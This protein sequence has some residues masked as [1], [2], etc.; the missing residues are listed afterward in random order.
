MKKNS[1]LILFL[2]AITIALP[3]CVKK[4]KIS[5]N[6]SS[7]D[8]KLLPYEKRLLLE[9]EKTENYYTEKKESTNNKYELDFK[10]KN[11]TG[12]TI[13]VVCFSYINKRSFNRWRWDKSPIYKIENN[14]EIIIDIDTINDDEYRKNTYGTL[15]IFNNL[16]K[17]KRSTYELLKEK[18]K[19]DL[20]KLHK[21]K[22]KTVKINIRKYGFKGKTLELK[23]DH[24]T[25]NY[26]ELDFLVENKTGKNLWICSF[27]YQKKNDMPIWN[28]AK[29]S[30]K[31]VK[32]N[33]SVII[34]VDTFTNKYNKVFMLGFLAVFDEKQ[35]KEIEQ[36]TYELL[37]P[38]NKIGL[39]RLA[40]LRNKK[41]VLKIEQYGLKNDF[42][43]ISIKPTR[44]IFK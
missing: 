31:L 29:T 12:K 44:K 22:N 3:S 10:V 36:I 1:K 34:D 15:G 2:I 43:D 14:K 7:Q 26:N 23:I 24:D 11:K 28:F 33:K 42:L 38:E 8:I 27:I 35:K 4:S 39:G 20:D 18:Y 13:Y 37:K 16:E 6:S 5:K 25:N 19:L 21:L 30:I 32:N 17:A 40:S 41:I 9:E